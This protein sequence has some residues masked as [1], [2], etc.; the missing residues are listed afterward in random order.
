MSTSIVESSTIRSCLDVLKTNAL[1]VAVGW[2]TIRTLPP[3]YV[4]VGGDLPGILQFAALMMGTT[5]ISLS[6]ETSRVYS[7]LT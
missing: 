1:V 6:T 7:Q 3:G 5:R 2:W 4:R